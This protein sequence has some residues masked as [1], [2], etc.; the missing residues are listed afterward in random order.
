MKQHMLV[1]FSLKIVNSYKN[2]FDIFVLILIPEKNYVPNKHIN[3][4]Y[5]SLLI[6]L[7]L[8][9]VMYNLAP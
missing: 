6:M 2:Y 8:P 9:A 7:S 3:L 5:A 1:T 4:V